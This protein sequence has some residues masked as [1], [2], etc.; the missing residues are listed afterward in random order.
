MRR[1]SQEKNK[2]SKKEEVSALCGKRE[3]KVIKAKEREGGW[4]KYQ[5][6][7]YDFG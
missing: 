7:V 4:V 5:H 2:I 3:I 1:G 6:Q